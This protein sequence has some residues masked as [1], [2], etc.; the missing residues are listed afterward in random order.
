MYRSH[1]SRVSWRP[2]TRQAACARCPGSR[3]HSTIPPLFV[4]VGRA[5]RRWQVPDIDPAGLRAD[6]AE[7]WL[8]PEL[9]V[10][11]LLAMSADAAEHLLCAS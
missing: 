11:D 5:A 3:S 8:T 7:A 4:A 1:S 10:K 2:A 6:A 9:N